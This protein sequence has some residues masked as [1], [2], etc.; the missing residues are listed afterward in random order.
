M[1]MAELLV[2]QIMN[3][4][5]T[6]VVMKHPTP[7]LRADLGRVRFGMFLDGKR[8][9]DLTTEAAI[10]PFETT[11]AFHQSTYLP[12]AIAHVNATVHG[13]TAALRNANAHKELPPRAMHAIKLPVQIIGEH[14][15][16]ADWLNIIVRSLQRSIPVPLPVLQGW[17]VRNG[18]SPASLAVNVMSDSTSE[19]SPRAV[20][21]VP[22]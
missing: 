9:I 1:M 21:T 14:S 16:A 11:F 18:V 10:E 17:L 19:T 7:N 22:V 3:P 12:D 5:G 8:L 20:D 4:A 13:L 6:T 2:A 15:H